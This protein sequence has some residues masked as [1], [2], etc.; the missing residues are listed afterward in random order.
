[1]ASRVEALQAAG[2]LDRLKGHA[3]H[4]WLLQGELDDGAEFG[5]IGTPFDGHHQGGRDVQT[6]QSVEG[7]STHC[8][9]IGST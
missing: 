5:I 9:Q 4:A 6:V 7:P 8:P 1:V 2:R 3:A